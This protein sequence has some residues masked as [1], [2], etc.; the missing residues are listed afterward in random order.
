MAHYFAYGNLLDIDIMRR[1]APSARAV[2]VACLDDQ[3][4]AFAKC[5]DPS[6]GG[7]TLNAR[8]GAKTWG[9]QYELSDT[10]MVTLDKAAGVEKGHWR[11]EKITLRTKDGGTI[12]ST[13]YVIPQESGAYSPPE[14][15]VAPIY[16]GAEDLDLPQDYRSRLREIIV[17]A[18]AAAG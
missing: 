10:D 11:Q 4:I 5:S 9:V 8:S 17:A 15:Y 18:Q 14:T 16:K 7:C 13:T 2:T 6:I 12:A 1:I 3:E